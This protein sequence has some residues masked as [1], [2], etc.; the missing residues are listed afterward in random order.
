MRAAKLDRVPPAGV[1]IEATVTSKGQI[2]LPKSLREQ[3]GIETGTRIRFVLDA[4]GRF[5]GEPVLQELEDLWVVA[6]A[7]PRL[8]KPMTAAAMDA[9]KAKRIW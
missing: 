8:R 5:Q 9:A 2:T 1:P 4:Q 7:A 3:L 6:D